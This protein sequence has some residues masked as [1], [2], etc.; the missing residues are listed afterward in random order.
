MLIK[1]IQSYLDKGHPSSE[2]V[3]ILTRVHKRRKAHEDLFKSLDARANMGFLRIERVA[4]SNPAYL[5][6]QNV[7]SYA[8]NRIVVR[9]G[10]DA[11]DGTRVPGRPVLSALISEESL[12]QLMLSPNRSSSRIGLTSE[13]LLGDRLPAR[14]GNGRRSSGDLLSEALK[15]AANRR[16]E[17][18]NDLL[19]MVEGIDRGI[20]KNRAEDMRHQ[21]QK[22]L[23]RH[24]GAF[25]LSRH[26][27]N[28]QKDLVQYRVEASSAALNIQGIADDVKRLQNLDAPQDDPD[29]TNLELGRNTNPLLD[30][31]MGLYRPEEALACQKAVQFHLAQEIEDTF[32]GEVDYDARVDD[33]YGRIIRRAIPS[34]YHETHLPH[35]EDMA[36]LSSELGNSAKN[37][38]REMTDG[39]SLTASCA[40]ISGGANDLHTSFPL[41]D[42]GYFALRFHSA[43]L[44]D[45]FGNEKIRE[46]MTFLEIGLSR[47]DMMTALRGH[48]SGE[49]IPCSIDRLAGRGV[50]RVPQ[51]SKIEAVIQTGG[52]GERL[53]GAYDHLLKMLNES[54]GIIKS[55]ARKVSERKYLRDLL[56]QV[57][58]AVDVVNGIEAE[59]IGNRADF[60]NGE[61]R[62]KAEDA[63]SDIDDYLMETQGISL[64]VLD[65]KAGVNTP[66]IGD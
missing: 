35:F 13:A 24:D 66:E 11:A 44:D 21:L 9:L 57:R 27:E 32:P 34:T 45:N 42:E 50:E 63:L 36:I 23:S 20:T 28:L 2:E 54:N 51:N 58:D 29:I 22:V 33:P 14:T 12:A 19:A 10:E 53:R 8:H 38:L 55:G 18:V 59:D 15:G 1:A 6:G 43:V 41:T 17:A 16:L 47:E 49:D 52:E 3:S 5:F 64:A 30:C 61:I 48:P 40:N 39:Y 4:S 7:P 65:S 62:Q 46:G 60:L 31:A 25:V 56:S 26:L 37:T